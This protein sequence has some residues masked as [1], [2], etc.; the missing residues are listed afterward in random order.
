MDR[1]LAQVNSVLGDFAHLFASVYYAI[2][3]DGLVDLEWDIA[4]LLRRILIALGIKR[5]EGRN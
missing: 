3:R 1:R 5:F 4:V 2:Q